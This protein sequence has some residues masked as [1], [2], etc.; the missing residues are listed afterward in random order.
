VELA[1]VEPVE[2]VELEDELLQLATARPAQ[3]MASRWTNGARFLKT[4]IPEI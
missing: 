3:P 4:I 1:G 2:F